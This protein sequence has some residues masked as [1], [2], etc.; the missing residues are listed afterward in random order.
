MRLLF[1]CDP[2]RRSR[3]E[4]DF[5]LELGFASGVGLACGLYS[6]EALTAGGDAADAVRTVAT[7]ASEGEPVLLRGW[8]VGGETY[9]S[10]HEALVARGFS[11]LTSPAAYA[12]AH[13]LPLAYAHLDGHTPESSWIEGDDPEAAWGLYN[14]G[15]RAQGDAIIKDWVKSAKHRWREACFLPAGSSREDFGRIFAAFRAARGGLFERGV[16]LRRFVPLASRGSDMRGFPLVEE[17]RLF[18]LGGELVA[19]PYCPGLPDPC[20]E[21]A[22][23]ERWTMLAR[24]FASPFLTL[25]VARLET[26]GWTVVEAGDGQVSGLPLAIEPPL[27]YASL[28][29]HFLDVDRG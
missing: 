20:A 19:R 29:N 18:F 14:A 5:A 25:D 26:G 11:P 21:P 3:V 8:M 2:L 13:Y 27:F 23:R 4:D 15:F 1:P 17:H 10:L 7:P 16:V 24:R 6:H 22:E 9:A 12:G 28:A